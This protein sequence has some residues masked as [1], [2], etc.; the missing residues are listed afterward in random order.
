VI[1]D[2]VIIEKLTDE[3]SILTGMYSICSKMIIELKAVK[4]LFLQ[5]FIWNKNLEKET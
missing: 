5:R 1:S 4:V 3:S 2:F